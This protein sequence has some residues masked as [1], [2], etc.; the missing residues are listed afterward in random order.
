MCPT[1]V[2]RSS[3]R[4]CLGVFDKQFPSPQPD[5]QLGWNVIH[6]VGNS[7]SGAAFISEASPPARPSSC[8]RAWGGRS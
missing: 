6:G 5:H 1:E 4:K 8:E 2:G 3:R 7:S